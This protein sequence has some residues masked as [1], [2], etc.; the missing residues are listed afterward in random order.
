MID[1]IV[2][3]RDM[4]DLVVR[5]MKFLYNADLLADAAPSSASGSVAGRDGDSG[6]QPAEPETKA[7]ARQPLSFPNPIAAR[8]RAISSENL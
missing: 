7:E 2:A 4:R 6:P 3:R 5:C 8:N 1:F